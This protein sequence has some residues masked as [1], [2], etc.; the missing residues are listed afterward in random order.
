M[1]RSPIDLLDGA[2]AVAAHDAG[3]A[4]MLVQWVKTARHRPEL[5]CMDGPAL[6][7]W[8]R[9]LGRADIVDVA[10]LADC[11]AKVLVSGTGWASDLEHDARRIAAGAGITNV[12][13]IDH[14]VNYQARFERNG[15][16]VLPDTI[17][18][19]DDIARDL[20]VAAFPGIPVETWPNLYI[21]AEVAAAGPVPQAGD[22]LFVAEPARSLWGR[23]T[24]GEF[25]ALDWFESHAPAGETAIRLR[26]HPS[27]PPGKYDAWIDGKNRWA[28]DDSP[29][30]ATALRRAG[31]VVGMNSMAMVV[32]LE[33]GRRV[34]CA[35]PPWGPPCAL[36]HPSIARIGE[37][38]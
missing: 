21:Q 11:D 20:A 35:I 30:L 10:Q 17:V 22:T 32:A 18:V 7:I 15:Q 13:V 5:A 12:A 1:I 26:P 6:K 23:D 36:P 4:N 37:A 25:Q 9:E 38:L 2:Y 16:T 24:Q 27:D 8:E 31:H 3:A 28:L 33:A 29:D 34:S 14:W 19:G